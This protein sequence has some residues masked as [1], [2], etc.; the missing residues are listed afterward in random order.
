[1]SWRASCKRTHFIAFAVEVYYVIDRSPRILQIPHLSSKL[2]E[3]WLTS[4][5]GFGFP[6]TPPDVAPTSLILHAHPSPTIRLL[7]IRLTVRV[8]MA[9]VG[10]SR[11]AKPVE[12]DKRTGDGIREPSMLPGYVDDE[13]RLDRS[14]Q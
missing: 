2:P 6:F 4:P 5:F 8:R 12:A 11:K 7:P 10:E 1:M 9:W 3:R 14:H 13:A